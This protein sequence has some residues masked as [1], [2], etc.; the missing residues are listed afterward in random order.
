MNGPVQRWSAGLLI[1]ASLLAVPALIIAGAWEVPLPRRDP[2]GKRF[3]TVVG[4]SPAN[5]YIELPTAF[6]GSPKVM[7]IGYRKRAGGDVD[8]WLNGLARARVD[9]PV[10][11]VSTIP[12]LLP[13][14]DAGQGGEQWG[15]VVALLGIAA[16]P[17]ARLTGTQPS[18][19]ARVVVLDRG[20][21]IIWF[22]DAG[23]VQE[24]ALEVAALVSARG[25]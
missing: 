21:Q 12:G 7:V 22:D 25:S 13:A 3:P 2:T 10:V 6:A 14:P 18:G 19:N 4:E 24:K 17:V 5:E 9:T 16:E 23:F 20:D 11:R 8:R 1:S 15:A